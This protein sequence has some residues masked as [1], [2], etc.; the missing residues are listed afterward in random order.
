M[1][2][3]CVIQCE[4]KHKHIKCLSV[5]RCC[6]ISVAFRMFLLQADEGALWKNKCNYFFVLCI[7]VLSLF[8]Y[9]QAATVFLSLTLISIYVSSLLIFCPFLLVSV[10]GHK[11]ANMRD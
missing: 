11:D 4:G 1:S 8:V 10:C 5:L 3:S 6:C 2:E 9:T 7:V